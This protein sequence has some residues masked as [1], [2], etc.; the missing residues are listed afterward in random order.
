MDCLLRPGLTVQPV[1]LPIGEEDNFKGVVQ[2]QWLRAYAFLRTSDSIQWL[3]P[4]NPKVISCSQLWLDCSNTYNIPIITFCWH[5]SFKLVL[6][7]WPRQAQLFTSFEGNN[8]A[9]ICDLVSQQASASEVANGLE[10]WCTMGKPWQGNWLRM[11]CTQYAPN[12][13][14]MLM[15]TCLTSAV[16]HQ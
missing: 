10:D 13:M 8:C 16:R 9:G 15:T 4:K 3:R 6:R 7:C 14:K 11:T 5:G 12:C 2:H 1:Q